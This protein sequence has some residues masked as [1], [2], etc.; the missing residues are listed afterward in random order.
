MREINNDSFIIG[1]S[2][3]EWENGCLHQAMVQLGGLKVR[4]EAW[5]PGTASEPAKG[6]IVWCKIRGTPL[7][8]WNVESFRAIAEKLAWSEVLP[9]RHR[10]LLLFALLEY[11]WISSGQVTSQPMIIVGGKCFWISI[12][13]EYSS[14]AQLPTSEAP[15]WTWADIVSPYK[16]YRAKQ[17]VGLCK[18]ELQKELVGTPE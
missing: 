11:G 6:P 12:E 8:L 16:Q 9:R 2:T 15:D 3:D 4:F 13:M 14:R 1:A 17:N 5:R 7:H 18:G 10:L